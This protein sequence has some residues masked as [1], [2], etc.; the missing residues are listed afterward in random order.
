MGERARCCTAACPAAFLIL[1]GCAGSC[2]LYIPHTSSHGCPFTLKPFHRRTQ[3]PQLLDALDDAAH[4]AAAGAAAAHGGHTGGAFADADGR[5]YAEAAAGACAAAGATCSA[6]AAAAAAAVVAMG[7]RD[8]PGAEGSTGAPRYTETMAD[9]LERMRR[10]AFL[11][12]SV[13][14]GLH[15]PGKDAP[16]K[17]RGRAR[18]WDGW[19]TGRCGLAGPKLNQSACVGCVGR[20]TGRGLGLGWGRLRGRVC[21]IAGRSMVGANCVFAA[22][23]ARRQQQQQQQQQ[24][25]RCTG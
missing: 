8:V 1:Q 5:R 25:Q 6:A 12:P 20:G 24:Q 16:F 9:V 13:W 7:P 3:S 11:D 15:Q 23:Q 17:V 2:F 18:A 21:R 4:A 19:G 22:R 14:D 10:L